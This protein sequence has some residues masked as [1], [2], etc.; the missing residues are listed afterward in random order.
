MHVEISLAAWID[1]VAETGRNQ[2]LACRIILYHVACSLIA[3]TAQESHHN[4]AITAEGTARS[5]AHLLALEGWVVV[6]RY[7]ASSLQ[8]TLLYTQFGDHPVDQQVIVQTGWAQGVACS[9]ALNI[10]SRAF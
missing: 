8:A 4:R 3:C 1:V 10:A 2:A 5:L 7:C 6:I 9:Q